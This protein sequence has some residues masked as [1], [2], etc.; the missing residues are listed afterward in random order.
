MVA[1]DIAKDFLSDGFTSP[2]SLSVVDILFILCINSRA[3]SMKTLANLF[4][5]VALCA[6]AAALGQNATVT[7]T[8]TPGL[9][10]LAGNG[11]SQ[12]LLS[13]NDWWG[14]IRA[15]QDLAGD[16]GK[17]VDKN[18]TLANWQGGETTVEYIYRPVTSFVN[19]GIPFS[20]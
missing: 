17:V 1:L 2:Q 16:I 9:L 4:G 11:E 19:V 3:A 7:T 12:I 10:Q 5:L 15:A 14:V 18:L 13:T 6:S 8:Y 20:S